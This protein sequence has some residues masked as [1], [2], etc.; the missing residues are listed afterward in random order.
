VNTVTPHWGARRG[1]PGGPGGRGRDDLFIGESEV[2]LLPWD[3]VVGECADIGCQFLGVELGGV[4]HNHHVE[5]RVKGIQIQ[6][7]MYLSIPRSTGSLKVG[8]LK[9][10]GLAQ[11]ALRGCSQLDPAGVTGGREGA[12]RSGV[13]FDMI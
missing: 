6:I 1:G 12:I 7:Q 5:S 9:D 3:E 4:L 11:M 2:E 13:I 10:D 8:I